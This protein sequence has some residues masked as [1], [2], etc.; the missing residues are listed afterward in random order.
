[1]DKSRYM[2]RTI[3]IPSY[4]QIAITL[5]PFGQKKQKL[6]SLR[7]EYERNEKENYEII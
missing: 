5:G 1:M 6:M 4:G 2:E 7:D 3:K